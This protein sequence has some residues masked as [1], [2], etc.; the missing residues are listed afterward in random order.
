[1]PFVSVKMYKGRTK[2]QKDK[3]VKEMTKDMVEILKIPKEAIT[4]VYEEYDKEN[5]SIA[6]EIQ[7]K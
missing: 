4:I 2:E 7:D 6:G 5:W 1:M 3:L